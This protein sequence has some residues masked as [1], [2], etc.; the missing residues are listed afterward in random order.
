MKIEIRD[1]AIMIDGYV[2]AVERESKV[3][4]NRSGTFVEKIRAGAFKRALDRAK[5]TSSEVRVLLNHNYERQL[6]S[7]RDAT[8]KIFEDAIGLRCQCEIRDAEVI[9]KAKD[10]KLRGWS[11]GFTALRDNWKE[12]KNDPNRH[13]EVRELDLK[14]VSILDDTKIPAYDGTSI[15]M[16]DEE[17]PDDLIEVR[18]FDDEETEIEDR[19]TPET[20]DNHE[21]ENRYLSTFI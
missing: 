1:D 17:I 14:E 8:T 15:E 9:Q 18:V 10:H 7:T 5:R 4:H 16:R 21:Y 2:N 13:R 12:V 3:L 20:V 11:F 19:S 6:T